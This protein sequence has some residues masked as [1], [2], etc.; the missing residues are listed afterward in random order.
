MEKGG[1][2]VNKRVTHK[3]EHCDEKGTISPGPFDESFA[4]APSTVNRVH[5]LFLRH[6]R[7]LCTSDDRIFALPTQKSVQ[8]FREM[9]L[10]KYKSSWSLMRSNKTCFGCLRAVPDHMLECGHAFCEQCVREL[11]TPSEYFEYG[12]VLNACVLCQSTWQDGR[13]LFRLKPRCAGVRVLTL[14]GG[15]IRGMVEISLLEKLH[16]EI[17]IDIP[18]REFFDLIIGTSTGELPH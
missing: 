14:D 13:N 9:Q 2:C 17:D 8:A 11:G 6:Y 10:Q 12:W 16:T 18:L 15:G 1:P 3:Y 4:L 5:N 7:Y